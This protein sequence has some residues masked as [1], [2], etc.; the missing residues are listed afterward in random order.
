MATENCI[1]NNVSTICNEY[2]SK[3]QHASLKL[4]NICSAVYITTQKAALLS[5]GSVVRTFVAERW[6][7]SAWSVTTIFFW[8]PAELMKQRKWIIIIIIII[9]II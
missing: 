6:I 2:Y 8:E 9:I 4:L 3:K 5:K 1:Y 7:R